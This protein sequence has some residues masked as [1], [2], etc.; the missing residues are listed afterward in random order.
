MEVYLAAAY[1]KSRKETLDDC[2][3]RTSVFLERLAPIAEKFSGWRSGGRSKK[4]ALAQEIITPRSTNELRAK[5]ENGRNR[6]D[7]DRSVIEELGYGFGFW[8]GRSGTDGLLFRFIAVTII[9]FQA[10]EIMS[11]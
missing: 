1:W 4:E 5:F 6:R 3:A 2:V 7:L 10:L 8:N 11:S 9:H